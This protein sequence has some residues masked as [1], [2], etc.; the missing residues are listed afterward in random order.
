MRSASIPRTC[1]VCGVDFIAYQT[2]TRACS[3]RCRLRLWRRTQPKKPRR[4]SIIPMEIAPRRAGLSTNPKTVY[5]RAQ[6]RDFRLRNREKMLERERRYRASLPREVRQR[7]QRDYNLKLKYGKTFGLAQ[8]EAMLVAQLGGCAI[9]GASPAA[10]QP[11]HVDHDHKTNLVRALLCHPCNMG[12]I[13]VDACPDWLDRARAY[14]ERHTRR[15][16]P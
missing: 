14:V 3:K 10:G 1:T 4:A 5:N 6:V 9:C 7:R 11:L 12:M 16:T 13:A 2:R 15:I 8:Y